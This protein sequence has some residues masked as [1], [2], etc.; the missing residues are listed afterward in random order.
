[1]YTNC[2]CLFYVADQMAFSS[3]D[4]FHKVLSFFVSKVSKER[5]MTTQKIKI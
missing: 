3:S 2:V 4:G 1:M 5:V